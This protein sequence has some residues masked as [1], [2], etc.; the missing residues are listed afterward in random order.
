M[1]LSK[2]FLVD[3]TTIRE[4]AIKNAGRNIKV[5]LSEMYVRLNPTVDIFQIKKNKRSKM[6]APK[7]INKIPYGNM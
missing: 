2:D 3:I 6:H 1:Y 5:A 4:T 7:I